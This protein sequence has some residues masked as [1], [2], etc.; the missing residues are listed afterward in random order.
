MKAFPRLG[1]HDIDQVM[2]ERDS[3]AAETSAVLDGA[4]MLSGAVE[5][6]RDFAATHGLEAGD[7]ARLCILVEELVANLSDHGTPGPTPPRLSLLI[8]AAAIRIRLVDSGKPFDPRRAAVQ[9]PH[10]E[11]GGGAGLAIVRAWA[12]IEDYRS[13]RN[14]NRLEIRFPLGRGAGGADARSRRHSEEQ[15]REQ[16]QAARQGHGEIC[17]D[18]SRD[19]YPGAVRGP[20]H[21]CRGRRGSGLYQGKEARGG[22]TGRSKGIRTLESPPWPSPERAFGLGCGRAQPTKI[23]ALASRHSR[24]V[25]RVA[26]YRGWVAA[27]ARE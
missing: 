2:G 10:Q 5:L 23:A 16:Q 4:G 19:R 26:S 20:D 15:I 24:A 9:S 6:A 18:R 13:D 17:R 7:A 8:E 21:R 1:L 3:E 25:I 11:R 14:G 22:L 27:A 12:E